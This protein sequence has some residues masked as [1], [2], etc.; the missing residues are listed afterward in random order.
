MIYLEIDCVAFEGHRAELKISNVFMDFLISAVR[1][2]S[3]LLGTLES[4]YLT[5]T[6]YR[7]FTYLQILPVPGFFFLTTTCQIQQS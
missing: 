1:F 7:F 5:F 2:V 6:N 4:N 3:Y